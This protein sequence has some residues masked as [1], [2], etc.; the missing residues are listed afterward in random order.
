[1]NWVFWF[2]IMAWVT[3]MCY[4]VDYTE[5]KHN[6]KQIECESKGGVIIYKTCVKQSAVIEVN[7]G[8]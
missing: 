7:N 3:F 6:L 8:K 4:F 2:G 1:M 5:S